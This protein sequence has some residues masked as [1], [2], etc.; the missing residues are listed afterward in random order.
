MNK[1]LFLSNGI[2]SYL[3]KLKWLFLPGEMAIN[4]WKSE[5]VISGEDSFLYKL[6]KENEKLIKECNISLF[7]PDIYGIDVTKKG[8]R[9]FAHSNQWRDCTFQEQV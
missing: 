1:L 2:Y 8:L 4:G 3:S 6:A 9:C 5:V 7:I